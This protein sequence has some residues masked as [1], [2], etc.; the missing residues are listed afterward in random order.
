MIRIHKILLYLFVSW[1]ATSCGEPVPVA[2][3]PDEEECATEQEGGFETGTVAGI[4][5]GGAAVVALVSGNL[6][7]DDGGGEESSNTGTNQSA[8]QVAADDEPNEP[9]QNAADPSPNNCE[10][11]PIDGI[12]VQNGESVTAFSSPSV[13]FGQSCLL[14]TRKCVNGVLSGSYWFPTCE[15]RPPA[16]CSLGTQTIAHGKTQSAFFKS[17]VQSGGT[18]LREVRSC[19][20]GSLSGSFNYTTCSQIGITKIKILNGIEF[21]FVWVPSGTFEMGGDYE[22]DIRTN[23]TF[24]S[25]SPVHSVTFTEGFWIGKYEITQEQYE[26]IMGDN[27]TPSF[28]SPPF[29]RLPSKP[30]INLEYSNL[31]EFTDYLE[32]LDP[33]ATYRIPT[34]AEWEYACSFS[35]DGN[36]NKYGTASGLITKLEAHYGS[37]SDDGLSVVGAYPGNAL[38]IHD[39]S[40]NAAE[41]VQYYGDYTSTPKIDVPFNPDKYNSFESN[42]VERGGSFMETT[43]ILCTRR[44]SWDSFRYTQ[45][46]DVGFRI[47]LLE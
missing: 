3:T 35:V 30:V 38:G 19:N 6:D 14:E 9:E 43:T 31:S 34:E 7:S 46:E 36:K 2:C 12:L 41:W 45:Y 1:L 27:P 33:N 40:G 29:N 28:N 21:S 37:R 17:Y 20:N 24:H 39:M 16:E 44:Y 15:V 18:C 42:Y 26:G 8:E 10:L 5:A 11:N 4:A 13:P 32:Y 23:D 22:G 25:E 47:I